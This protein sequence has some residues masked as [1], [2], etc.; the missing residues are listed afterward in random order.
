[1]HIKTIHSYS[2][3]TFGKSL[4]ENVEHMLLQQQ[5]YSAKILKKGT[6]KKLKNF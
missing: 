6:L 2:L 5:N 3:T 1:M 4:T